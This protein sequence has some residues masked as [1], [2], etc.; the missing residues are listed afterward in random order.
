MEK[1]K[2]PICGEPTIIHYGN[3][4]KYGLCAYHSKQLKDGE[5]EIKEEYDKEV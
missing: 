1:L 2:C 5:I 4:Q 3:P